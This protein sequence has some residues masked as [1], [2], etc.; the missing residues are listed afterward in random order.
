MVK[1]VD[2]Y[3]IRSGKQAHKIPMLANITRKG[4]VGNYILRYLLD[5]IDAYKK[6]TRR[7]IFKNHLKIDLQNCH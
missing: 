1:E 2:K 5:T 6:F 3:G 4:S 7:T